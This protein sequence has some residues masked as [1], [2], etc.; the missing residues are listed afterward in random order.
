MMMA[1]ASS[2][3]SQPSSVQVAIGIDRDQIGIGAL[4]HRLRHAQGVAVTR[5]KNNGN[6]CHGETP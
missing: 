2:R 5:M 6:F 1:S 3:V 4:S